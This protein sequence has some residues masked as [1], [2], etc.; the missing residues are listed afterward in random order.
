MNRIIK[1]SFALSI[2]IAAAS[3]PA[4]NAIALIDLRS[5]NIDY[6]SVDLRWKDNSS[7]GDLQILQRKKSAGTQIKT[8]VRFPHKADF[9]TDL[10]L[11]SNTTYN[12]RLATREAN[13]MSSWAE[14]TVRTK[15]NPHTGVF[16]V[17]NF[18]AKGNGSTNDTAAIRAAI[19]E[20]LKNGG[21]VYFPAGT[22]AVAPD[23]KAGHIF[24][25]EKG[26]IFFKGEGPDKSII[27]C[28]ASGLRNPE[29]SWDY[30]DS[31]NLVRGMAFLLPMDVTTWHSNFVFEDL[32]VTGN[33]RPTGETAWW[34]NEQKE[35]GWD[36]SHKG[37]YLGLKN[38]NVFMRNCEWD[39]FRGEILYSG[40]AWTKKFKLVDCISTRI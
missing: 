32:R 35:N 11:E 38:V 18:G 5:E 36:F 25:I 10:G 30:T 17:K 26:N 27:S 22:Y 7:F 1:Y 9:Y 29:T 21:T 2:L 37:I 12:Y 20:A 3:S 24:Y 6:M 4:V 8:V 19:A 31:G 15:V 34:T 14:L 40:D 33:T 13:G 39:N 16:N 28:Y 23:P